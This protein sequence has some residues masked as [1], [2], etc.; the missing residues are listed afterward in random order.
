MSSKECFFI[1]FIVSSD[2]SADK[3]KIRV[4]LFLI[5]P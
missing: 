4:W 2:S 3:L 5:G 1:S